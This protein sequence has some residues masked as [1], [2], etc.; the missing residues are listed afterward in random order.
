M[1]IKHTAPPAGKFTRVSNDS[2]GKSGMSLEAEYI[3]LYL[4]SKPSHWVVRIHD[5][6]AVFHLTERTARRRMAEMVAAGYA[7]LRAII[8]PGRRGIKI[9]DYEVCQEPIFKAEESIELAR[10]DRDTSGRHRKKEG[11][12]QDVLVVK[13]QVVQEEADLSKLFQI[14]PFEASHVRA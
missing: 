10:N 14:K 2:F 3:H 11:Y 1:A 13:E 12:Q 7:R 4:M 8:E 5:I 6:A 9:W